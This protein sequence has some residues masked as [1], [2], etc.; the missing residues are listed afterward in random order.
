MKVLKRNEKVQELDLEKVTDS[1][2]LAAQDVGG[3]DKKLAQMIAQEVI[4]RLKK[5][6]GRIK[7]VSSAI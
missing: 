5:Q 7:S 1:I 6:Y 2:F 4:E 3:T